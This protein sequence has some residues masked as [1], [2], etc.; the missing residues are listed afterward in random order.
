MVNTS[1]YKASGSKFYG[2]L[3]PVKDAA[4]FDE[5]IKASKEQRPDEY[6]QQA[7]RDRIVNKI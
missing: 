4:D 7:V 1:E 2:Y 3:F 5:K 6:A